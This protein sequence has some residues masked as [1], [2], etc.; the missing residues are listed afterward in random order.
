MDIE[1]GSSHLC[2]LLR[3]RDSEPTTHLIGGWLCLLVMAVDPRD[4]AR[5]G[6][7]VSQSSGKLANHPEMFAQSHNRHLQFVTLVK[8]ILSELSSSA[9]GH[10]H[11]SCSKMFYDGKPHPHL[12][13]P[14]PRPPPYNW[15][16]CS[17]WQKQKRF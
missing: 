10:S 17:S 7:A 16:F 1:K 14:L 13:L 2:R 3:G 11:L 12:H 8:Y 5:S 15:C 4:C 9:E 6:A